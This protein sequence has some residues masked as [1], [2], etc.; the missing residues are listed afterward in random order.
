MNTVK[1]QYQ[2]KAFNTAMNHLRWESKEGNVITFTDNGKVCDFD[3]FNQIVEDKNL[4]GIVK[5]NG[6]INGITHI[7]SFFEQGVNN[8]K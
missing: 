2:S 4:S 1:I 8:G 3:K 5:E 6:N 7:M